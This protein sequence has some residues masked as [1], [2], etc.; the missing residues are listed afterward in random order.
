MDI[1]A[2]KTQERIRDGDSLFNMTLWCKIQ[3][4][5]K[6]DQIITQMYNETVT[7]SVAMVQNEGCLLEQ[8]TITFDI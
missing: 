5:L 4:V 2:T 7:P 3:I 8:I 6:S 1:N